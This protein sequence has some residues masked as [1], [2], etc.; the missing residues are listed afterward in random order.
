MKFLNMFLKF[1]WS[2]FAK[3]KRFMCIGCKDWT[4]YK[5]G[6]YLGTKIEAVIMQDDTNYGKEDGESNIFEKVT[7]KVSKDLDIPLNSEIV[8]KSVEAKVYGEYRNLISC[9]AEDIE[10]VERK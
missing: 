10:V 5:S 6:E 1:N 4:D 7:F 8:P 9:T 2:A 3:G